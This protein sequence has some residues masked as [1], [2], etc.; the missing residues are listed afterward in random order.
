MTETINSLLLLARGGTQGGTDPVP[1]KACLD[2]IIA[3]FADMVAAK[4]IKLE[5]S[6]APEAVLQVN[7]NAFDLVLT[8]LIKNAITYTEQGNISVRHEAQRLCIEDTGVGIAAADL[9]HVFER[10]YRGTSRTG[11]Q[12]GL[13]LGLAIVKS[14]C[15]QCG[16]RIALHSE[17]DRG[18]RVTIDFPPA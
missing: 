12:G 15:D 5:V 4:P 2:R 3:T 6:I 18:T 8:N 14:V 16:W 9:P 7:K 13:G 11:K 10:F 17:K 1:V